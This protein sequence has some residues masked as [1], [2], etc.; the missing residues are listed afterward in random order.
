MVGM[1]NFTD[2]TKS[3][4]W[5]YE[6]TGNATSPVWTREPTWDIPLPGMTWIR[7][8]FA[9]LDGVHDIAVF[10]LA[11]KIVAGQ[12]Y[13]IGVNATVIN[14][15]DRKETFNVTVYAN[16]KTIQTVTISLYPLDSAT[17]TF[18]WNTTGFAKGNYTIS[19]Y[20]WP[21][22]GE[23]G[24]SDNTLTDGIVYVSIP[25]DINADKK[26][27]VK[28]VYAVG[29]DFGTSIEGPNPPGRTY[30]PNCDINDDGKVDIK[31]YYTVCRHYGETDP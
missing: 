10:N 12:G 2:P 19:A 16:E 5:A 15:G 7:P 23:T 11:S 22:P 1:G 8:A 18:T 26:V 14:R 25:G 3:K 28:D 13:S 9:N 29:R 17:I 20:A 6:N 4:I 27:D 24:T 31:D 30:H 21:V